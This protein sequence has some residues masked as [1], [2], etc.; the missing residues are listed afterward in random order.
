MAVVVDEQIHWEDLRCAP[1]V[2]WYWC[3]SSTGTCSIAISQNNLGSWVISLTR[4]LSTFNQQL[5]GFS[6]YPLYFLL[7]WLQIELFLVDLTSDWTSESSIKSDVVCVLWKYPRR[8]DRIGPKPGLPLPHP[9]VMATIYSVASP[10]FT[11]F[12]RVWERSVKMGCSWVPGVMVSWVPWVVGAV[13]VCFLW[14]L[15]SER[16]SMILLIFFTLGASTSWPCALVRSGMH[17]G[18]LSWRPES[19]WCPSGS[20]SRFDFFWWLLLGR[21]FQILV[22]MWFD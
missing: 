11:S 21:S 9:L 18:L 2:Y 8:R 1:L 17:G 20:W 10:I 12:S 13:V 16:N 19:S 5:Q 6:I 14:E 15:V 4:H 3:N 7:T 22:L